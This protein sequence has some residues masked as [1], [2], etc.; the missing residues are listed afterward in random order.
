MV[1]RETRVIAVA[2]LSAA[3]A[4][5]LYAVVEYSFGVSTD[6]QGVV[7]FL[8]L[9]VVG[10]AAPQAYLA[11]T[12]ASVPSTWRF[13]IVLVVLLV[14]AGAFAADMPTPQAFVVWGVVGAAFLLVVA[15]EVREGYLASTGPGSDRS[16]E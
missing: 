2:L 5:A 3:F 15:Y 16:A 9:A 6:W 14:L 4:L 10:V 1:S 8:V 13:G 7:V 11:R 12:D